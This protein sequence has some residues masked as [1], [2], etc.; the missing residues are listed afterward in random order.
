M[1]DT[2]TVSTGRAMTHREVMDLPVIG[3]NIMA[4]TRMAPG[5]QVPGTTQFLVQGQVGGGSAYNAP[6][7][8][9]GNEWSIDGAS[10]NGTDRRVSI[11]PSPDIID[12]FKI[13][14]SNFDA[15]FGHAT[16]L[17]ISMSTKSGA[18]AFHGTGTM[19]YLNQRWNAASFFVKQQRYSQIAALRAA[20]NI[21]AADELADRPMLPPGTTKNYHATISGPIYIPKVIDGRNK[22][23]FFL[24]YSKLINRQS[25]RPSEI[26][27]TVPTAAMRNGDFSQLLT[28]DPIRYQIY[29]PLT[30]RPDPARAGHW[31]RDPFPGNIIPRERI[32]NPMYNFY[33]QRM[34]LPN[35]VTPTGRSP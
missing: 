13:E 27:Y 14:T 28:V 11:M 10:T 2:S 34:P 32:T 24:G 6:G 35:V 18:N 33:A 8:V 5:V 7:N 21:A 17:G 9:G 30:T 1:L 31:V 29:D 25:A 4:L 19:Q 23:F 22:L 3:N 26:N 16:G 12:E 20:G 15:S